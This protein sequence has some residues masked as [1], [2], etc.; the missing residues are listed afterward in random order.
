MD[1]ALETG[2]GTLLRP[3]LRV[4]EDSYGLV[5]TAIIAA[6]ILMGLLSGKPWG[7]TVILVVF[8]LVFFLTLQTSV[9]SRRTIRRS[10]R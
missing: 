2:A 3:R 8:L 6:L 9:V 4:I 10:P 7:D 1:E 5:L